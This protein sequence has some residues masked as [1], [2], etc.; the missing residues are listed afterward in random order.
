M[1]FRSTAEEMERLQLSDDD[2]EDLWNSPSK[3]GAQKKY[4]AQT[5]EKKSTPE[6]RASHDGGDPLFDYK[7]AR[8]AAL[9]T[10][11]QGVRN[12][13]EVIEGLLSSLDSAK[14]NMETVSRTVT[15]ASTLLNTWTRILSQTEHNQRLILNPS[16][17]GATQ[18]VADLENETIQRQQAAERREQLLQQ[19]REAAARKAQEVEARRTQVTRGTRGTRGI[20]RATVRSTGLGRT[21]SVSTSRTATRGSTA[22]S[23]PGSGIAR[24]S[25]ISRDESPDI[26]RA[27]SPPNDGY[28]V[29]PNL[30]SPRASLDAHVN[31]P[32]GH[33]YNSGGLA[34]PGPFETSLPI[35]IEVE[36]M[37]AYLLL[38]PVGGVL[39][40]L[41]EHNS[42]YVRFHAWQSSMVF[43]V[44]FV[45]HLIFC[46]SSFL[47]WTLLIIDLLLIAFLAMHAYQDV[48]TLDHFEVPI[49]GRLANSFVDDE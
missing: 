16:W 26:E 4:D 48:D 49:F 11:L 45:I 44:M 33:N 21:P 25:G 7:E 35:R 13:N 20:T 12:I 36:A 39:L 40:L 46:W 10:E 8:E 34:T 18:D 3:R 14:G 23:R 5:P 32:S 6:P 31:M 37:L 15:S 29:S 47:S 42:D 1:A 2:T 17:Q 27:L 24:G 9:Q 30:R 38:P 22:T 19:Q 41:I 43:A 28:R